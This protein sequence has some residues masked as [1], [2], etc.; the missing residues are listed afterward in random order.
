MSI[1]QHCLW[2]YLCCALEI[3]LR[4]LMEGV[5]NQWPWYPPDKASEFMIDNDC[6]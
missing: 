6:L 4:P 5:A 1:N 3:Q 2:T